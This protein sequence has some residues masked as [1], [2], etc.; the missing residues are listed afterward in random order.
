MKIHKT[1]VAFATICSLC[2][3]MPVGATTAD[4]SDINMPNDEECNVSFSASS[5]WTVTIPKNITMAVEGK[6]ASADY[7][8]SVKGRIIPTSFVTVVPDGGFNLTQGNINIPV[9]VIQETTKFRG[10]AFTLDAPKIV[11]G[12]VAATGIIAGDYTG[13]FNF[14]IAEVDHLHNYVDGVCTECNHECEHVYDNDGF[15]AECNYQCSHSYE[16]GTCIECGYQ[17]DHSYENGVCTLCNYKC[18]H[19]YENDHCTECGKLNPR[20]THSYTEEVTKEP[21][22]TETGVMLY[23]CTCGNTKKETI[24]VITHSYASDGL[25][26][27]CGQECVHS[28]ENDFCTVCGK[29]DDYNMAPKDAFLNWNYTLDEDNNIITLN[30]YTG[31]ETSVR[32]YANYPVADKTYKTQ[33]PSWAPLFR[34]CSKVESIR[35]SKL[36][37][38]SNV[39]SMGGMFLDC[40]ALVDLDISGFNTSNVVDL[41]E[42]FG[43]CGSLTS[44]D[45]SSF[46]TS[47]VTGMYGVF[48][49]CKSLTSIDLSSFDTSS[50]TTMESMFSGCGMTN[51]DL[52]CL[53]TSKVTT[54]EDMFYGCS[55]LSTV[56]FGSIDTSSLGTMRYMFNDCKSLQS[57]DL[58]GLTNSSVINL[59]S[60]FAGCTSLTSVNLEGFN[61][62]NVTDFSRMFLN[63]N[64]LTSID[65]SCIDMNKAG[66]VA[67]LFYGCSA[68]TSVNL[69]TAD[70][71]NLWQ[72]PYMFENC[73]SLT[74]LD[75]SG[76]DF[77]HA[78]YAD[79]MFEDCTN[80]TTIYVTEG[81]WLT[82]THTTDMF[83]NCGTSTVT[84][85]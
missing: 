68:L 84:Y 8:V 61:T 26:T 34:N 6:N 67:Q 4:T 24:P 7:E 22:C 47:K 27:I 21:T 43:G 3:P 33:F 49:S 15:C 69:G 80:L 74:S 79:S 75:L 17:C 53:D 12:S 63:C 72:V 23:T 81:K 78:G 2:V 36:I 60:L 76:W 77:S 51:L 16:N 14:H 46:D 85:K 41:R 29:P 45:L 20:H 42:L 31:D 83:K 13:S 66:A 44:I 62:S 48:R 71:V 5:E 57:I 19:T 73:S 52:S 64:S 10:D 59:Y 82:T 55:N 56:T 70:T 25:C 58:S 50:V 39:T 65:L 18:V 54:M 1:L 32:V 9:K 28:Y 11:T 35:F 38:T 40:K 37:D 30:S